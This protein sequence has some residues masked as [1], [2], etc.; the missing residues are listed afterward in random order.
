MN[1]ETKFYTYIQNNSGGHF[2][3][4]DEVCHYVII[5]AESAKEANRLAEDVGIYFDYDY[6]RD[7]SCCG[8]RWYEQDNYDGD[9]FPSV[10]GKSLNDIT[11][12]TKFEEIVKNM[13]KRKAEKSLAYIYYKDGTKGF[14]F[15]I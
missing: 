6:H 14:C 2:I 12:T 13:D 7:C 5:E 1:G 11:M 15:Y 3:I 10:Y 9:D 4:D 8:M